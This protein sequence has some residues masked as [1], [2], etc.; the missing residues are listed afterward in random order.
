M[1]D[2]GQSVT[3]GICGVCGREVRLRRHDRRVWSHGRR[4]ERGY[5]RC[6]GS[7]GQP[8]RIV[9]HEYPVRR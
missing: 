8:E 1:K 7:G 6:S 3:F 2:S 9:A 4:N 5:A